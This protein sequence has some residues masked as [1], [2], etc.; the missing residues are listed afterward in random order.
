MLQYL[1]VAKYI[2]QG[3][4]VEQI[5][6]LTDV[7][8]SDI[9]LIK[10]NVEIESNMQA[11]GTERF[12]ERQDGLKEAGKWMEASTTL[13][14]I[15]TLLKPFSRT[16]QEFADGY[17]A[18]KPHIAVEVFKRH[19]PF[20]LALQTM[21]TC[22]IAETTDR[23][24]LA[25][26]CVRLC[27]NIEKGLSVPQA[28]RVGYKLISLMCEVSDASFRI[29][30]R[31]QGNKTIHVIEATEK[32]YEWEEEQEDLM[33]ELATVFRPM[34][35]PP[36]PWTGLNTGG[37]WDADMQQPFIR[38]MPKATNKTH[39]PAAIPRVYEAV[40]K[41]Q[42]TPFKVNKFVLD[43]ANELVFDDELFFDKWFLDI[44]Q[45]P[46]K[47]RTSDLRVIIDK[48]SEALG[49]T[50]ENRDIHGKK[51]GAWVRAML[52]KIGI[53]SKEYKLKV[54]LDEARF[55]MVQYVNWRKQLT[56]VKSKNRVIKTALEVANDYCDYSR[57]Y[58]PDNLDWRMRVY[59]L[60]A[61]LTTQG[62]CLQKAL[63]KFAEGK[64][65]S[66]SKDP[67]R[68][69]EW[70]K[71]H[72]ANCFGKD[73]ES[74]N[75]RIK[76]TEENTEFIKSIAK[77]PVD[78]VEDWKNT[79]DPWLFIAACE[80]MQKYYDNGMDAVID[81][82]IPMDGTCNGAQHY[83]AMSRDLHGAYGVNVAPNG[84]TLTDD[85]LKIFIAQ[86]MTDEAIMAF[87]H[88]NAK[89]SDLYG[90]VAEVVTQALFGDPVLLEVL[91]QAPKGS[92]VGYLLETLERIANDELLTEVAE[93]W[94]SLGIN[95]K[96]TKSIVMTY[97]YGSTEYGNRDS[98]Q[99]R[100]DERAEEIL[101]KTLEP[102]F[103]RS[104]ADVWKDHRAKAVTVMVRLTRGAMGVVCPS[105]VAIM[106]L[107]Q[108]WAESLG[109]RD[110]PFKVTNH[111]GFTFYQ[112][113]PNTESKPVV[114]KENGKLVMRLFYRV[115]NTTGKRL[116]EKKMKSGAA[117]NFIHTHD[118]THLCDSTLRCDSTYF[119]HIHDSMAT[120]CADTP[121]LADS[122]RES[123]VGM[124]ADRDILRE[125][126]ELNGGEAMNLTP[127]P[128]LGTLDVREVLNSLYF[129]S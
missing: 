22:I 30:K 107:I 20:Q 13:K 74:W 18:K 15:K 60:S 121:D 57:I 91:K 42:A 10:A 101:E 7:N 37:Y 125:I 96:D 99:E 32:F 100:I 93:W 122:I 75:D 89:P 21:R 64:A 86:G 63:L 12:K 104:G 1:E 51:F 129:F 26:L 39:G 80:Q 102:Y 54:E 77:D 88:G 62:V 116:N 44:P 19:D 82:P 4:N 28:Y 31:Q 105:T 35:V 85:Q 123:F 87:A 11:L 103:D 106:D 33:A 73:K 47:E 76:W 8:V 94:K 67:E 72:T 70:L 49:I 53:S 118:A 24:E 97:L 23:K 43:T 108:S 52:A 84:M 25:A 38:N 127:P 16:I 27:E 58:I 2:K 9:E 5:N 109:A 95:R 17:T 40:N 120:Q 46:H 114:I 79:D 59:P 119:H 34:V 48:N 65:L 29:T 98:I 78:T 81:I 66:T 45:R 14:R 55:K 41:I 124:Y 36:R 90:A 83:S 92:P 111:L 112:D 68:A 128:P 126:W 56:S 69:L 113:N 117:P 50:P 115:P 61:G 6:I 71:V 3:L 110:I